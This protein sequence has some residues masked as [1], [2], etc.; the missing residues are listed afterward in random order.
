ML[1]RI[2][3]TS[4]HS[5]FISELIRDERFMPVRRLIGDDTRIGENEKD[6]R[7]N[8]YIN[9][10]QR[11]SST[12]LAHGWSPGSSTVAPKQMLNVG[13][14]LTDCPVENEVCDCYR[15]R[16]IRLLQNVLSQTLFRVTRT[17]PKE[18]RQRPGD[19]HSRWATLAPSRTLTSHWGRK[20]ETTCTCRISRM[21][22][23]QR[24]IRARRL[25][26][27]ASPWPKD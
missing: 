19:N 24:M 3:F 8:T 14:H 20:P 16:I 10:P 18:S 17:D 27:T 26:I 21:N 9:V 25:F 11:L 7:V 1:Q 12:G 15:A 13:L 23:S 6:G 22:F 4:L 5:G 2:P